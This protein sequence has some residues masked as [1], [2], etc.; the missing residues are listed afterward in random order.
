MTPTPFQLQSW[1][2]AADKA[3]PGPWYRLPRVAH[4]VFDGD[5]EFV[6]TTN[7]DS[8]LDSRT[9]AANAELIALARTAVPALLDLVAEQQKE[10]ERMKPVFEAALAYCHA[11]S[12]CWKTEAHLVEVAGLAAADIAIETKGRS[13]G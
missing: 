6:A 5:G 12:G 8:I 3:T 13:N 4:S 9:V 10:I 11:P 1:R 2:S 7:V